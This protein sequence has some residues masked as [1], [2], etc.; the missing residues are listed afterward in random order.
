[1]AYYYGEEF[2]SPY[3]KEKI[4]FDVLLFMVLVPAGLALRTA[5]GIE[6]PRP[7]PNKNIFIETINGIG[8]IIVITLI[9]LLV[10][11]IIAVIID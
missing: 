8:L 7:Y 5:L 4:M 2:L 10:T 1:M 9:M 6:D 3:R 11:Y